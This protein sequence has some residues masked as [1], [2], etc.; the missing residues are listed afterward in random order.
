MSVSQRWAVHGCLG[1]PEVSP[2][3]KKVPVAFVFGL[4]LGPC[5]RFWSAVV[6]QTFSKGTQKQRENRKL[7]LFPKAKALQLIA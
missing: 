2:K 1:E 4:G 6:I 7:K 3:P 5:S